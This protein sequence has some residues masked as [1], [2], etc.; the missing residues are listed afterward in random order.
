MARRKP[1]PRILDNHRARAKNLRLECLVD[2]DDD[3]LYGI[4]LERQEKIHSVAAA[5]WKLNQRLQKNGR[6]M[7]SGKSGNAINQLF[8]ARLF[9]QKDKYV[10]AFR[11]PSKPSKTKI[12]SPFPIYMLPPLD[13]K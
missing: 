10:I 2:V 9:D 4:L 3:D 13:W 6:T 11:N 5:F 1:Q 7:F 8:A 12:R